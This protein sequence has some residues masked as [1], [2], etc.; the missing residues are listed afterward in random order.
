MEIL[1]FLSN[2][3]SPSFPT[4]W[5]P[6]TAFSPVRVTV[7]LRVLYSRLFHRDT[8]NSVL[9]HVRESI[10][11][12]VELRAGGWGRRGGL[13]WWLWGIRSVGV[14]LQ[15]PVCGRLIL[16]TLTAHLVREECVRAAVTTHAFSSNNLTHWYRLARRSPL[17]LSNPKLWAFLD[18]DQ[19]NTEMKTFECFQVLLATTCLTLLFSPQEV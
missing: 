17:T 2:F 1:C 15:R 5:V 8:K 13:E 3:R 12:R 9:L 10:T 14:T 16:L 18:T 11:G 6:G 19:K 7:R 4:R